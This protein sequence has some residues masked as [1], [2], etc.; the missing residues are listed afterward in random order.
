VWTSIVTAVQTALTTVSTAITTVWET[1]KATVS[2]VLSA[3]GTAVS[4]AWN[5]IKNTVTTLM[6]AIKTG[7]TTAWESIK[8]TVSNV[9]SSIGTAISNGFNAAK[10]TVSNVLN[11]IKNTMSNI[12]DGAVNI[13]KGAV[14]KL[15][16][17]VN[18]QWSLP[19]IK[20]PHFSISGSF[21]LNPPS[22]PRISVEWYK[23]A[24]QDGLILNKPTVLPAADG[25]LRGYGDAGPEAVVGVSS[26][27]SMIND[28]VAAAGAGGNITIPVYIGQ[29]RIETIVVDAIQRNNYRS[30]G[31]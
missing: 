23:K 28:A 31:R 22:I 7:V 14:D 9:I 18:F 17:L 11:T 8:S 16:S 27:R 30:G 20:L 4:T 10:N 12:W 5:N 24:M 29:H 3:I 15:K 19:K 25:T 1:I 6:N 13:V 21:S 2:T 26:L